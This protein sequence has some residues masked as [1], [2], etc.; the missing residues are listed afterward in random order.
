MLADSEGSGTGCFATNSAT[1]GSF[2]KLD[3]LASF[4]SNG[5]TYTVN[6]VLRGNWAVSS[7]IGGMVW[8]KFGNNCASAPIAGPGCKVVVP[9]CSM[10]QGF[11][12]AKPMTNKGAVAWP[13]AV[14]KV[15]GDVNGMFVGTEA[16]QLQGQNLW[17][18]NRGNYPYHKAFFQAS[19][20]KLSMAAGQYRGGVSSV[21]NAL[22]MIDNAFRTNGINLLAPSTIPSGNTALENEMENAAGTIGSWIS[23]NHCDGPAPAL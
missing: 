10:S 9:S 6:I 5:S 11:Y 4:M 12:F 3:N 23:N 15:G 14:V 17:D 20:I 22:Q 8:V 1:V 21:D 16:T 7:S 18:N 19:A 13:S 2:I